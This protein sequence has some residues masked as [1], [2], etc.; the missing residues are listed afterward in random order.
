MGANSH[1]SDKR[2]PVA[3]VW[4]EKLEPEP[5]LGALP[6]KNHCCFVEAANDDGYSNICPACSPH[7]SLVSSQSGWVPARV[8]GGIRVSW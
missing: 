5:T 4:W 6:G 2:G 8:R 3:P 1:V 7:T